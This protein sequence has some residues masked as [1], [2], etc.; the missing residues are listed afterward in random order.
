VITADGHSHPTPFGF[1]MAANFG[2][3]S[4]LT[5][6]GSPFAAYAVR[7][8]DEQSA[9]WNWDQLAG[10]VR[11]RVQH[12]ARQGKRHPDPRVAETAEAWA[13][14]K[15]TRSRADLVET[16]KPAIAVD[17]LVVVL[18]LAAWPRVATP[19]FVVAV[20]G[21]IALPFFRFLLE[22]RRLRRLTRAS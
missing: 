19:Y 1:G 16:M 4:T 9:E 12:Y 8:G 5:P 7:V 22:Q 2:V 15:L 6:R 14:W 17:A 18:K 13:K 11:R 3:L 20:F 21:I 10:S